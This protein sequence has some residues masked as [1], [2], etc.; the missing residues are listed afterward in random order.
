MLKSIYFYE[1]KHWLKQPS[2]Y[3]FVSIMFLFGLGAMALTADITGDYS[4]IEKGSRRF[5]NAPF[6]IASLLF[7]FN[8]FIQFIVPIFIAG[9]LYRD[10]SS[11]MFMILYSYPI[12]KRDYLFGKFLSSVSICFIIV[13][14][15]FL[16]MF[17]GSVLPW[18]NQ[19][20]ITSNSIAA[21]IRPLFLIAV[22]NIAITAMLVYAAV[23]ASRSIY[24]GFITALLV[25]LLR[26]ILVF[27]LSGPDNQTLVA[28]F[29]LFA[30]APVFMAA[31]YWTPEQMNMLN[32]PISNMIIYN[33][34]IWLGF[35]SLIFTRAYQKFAFTQ[36]ILSGN[37]F[38]KTLRRKNYQ[39]AIPKSKTQDVTDISFSFSFI[40]QVRA[41]W[42]MSVFEFRN[43]LLSRTFLALLVGSLIFMYLLLAQ[44]NP[45]YTTRI[46]PLTQVMLMVPSLFFSFIIG[47]ITFLYAGILIHKDRTTDIHQLVDVTPISNPVL[48]GSK[49]LALIK[50]QAVLLSVIMVVGVLVQSIRG[51]YHFEIDLYLF[52][53]YAVS[54]IGLVI[55]A[56]LGFF[57]QTLLPNQYVGFFLLILF[58]IG[59]GGLESIGIKPDIFKFNAAP[60][61]EYSDLNG[62]GNQ[63]RSYFAHKLYWL[64]LGGILLILTFLFWVRGFAQNFPERVV[65]ALKRSSKPVMAGSSALLLAFLSMGFMLY[66]SAYP[67]TEDISEKEL[68]AHT[69]GVIK[70][71][72]NLRNI[73]QPR[74]SGVNINM[75]IFP[76]ERNYTSNGTLVFVNK[77]EQAID[78]LIIAYPANTNS[79]YLLGVNF[80][81]LVSDSLLNLDILKLQDPLL[82]KD[83]LFLEFSTND[84]PGTFFLSNSKV[85]EN[86]T[87][88]LAELFTVGMPDNENTH[89]LPSNPK[90]SENSYVGKNVDPFDFEAVVSTS[91]DQIALA[92]GE[93]AA[94]WQENGRNYFRYKSSRKIRNGIVFNSGVF[95]VK[96]EHVNGVDLEIYHHPTHTFN[97]ERMMEAMKAT[98]AFSEKTYTPYQFKQM[99]IIEFPK[100]YGNFAQSF[101]NTIPYSEFA[102]FISKEDTFSKNRFDQVFRLVAHEMAHQWWG[103]QVVPS[104]ALGS[105]IITEGLA[106]YTSIEILGEKYGEEAKQL[107]LELISD[108]LQRSIARTPNKSTPLVF[109]RPDQD[110]LNYQKAALTYYAFQKI[111]GK[112]NFH[113]GLQ[114][115]IEK[116]RLRSSPYP[117]SLDLVNELRNVTPDSFQHIISD[118]FESDTTSVNKILVKQKKF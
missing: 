115:F 60:I 19:A 39:S 64:L 110:I 26:R 34:L 67:G 89:T 92:P 108:R 2:T 65:T 40:T 84:I 32:I 15:L 37:I 11:K 13:L 105:R 22:P 111:I 51:Y 82:P 93:L 24:A 94:Q 30:Q 41:A 53:L 77:S 117:T 62:Y 100:T 73:I 50:I 54:L 5:A 12:K 56:M 55:W 36:S 45:Q 75:N 3:L 25:L 99:R 72:G 38:R 70:K 88:M 42:R 118:F 112:D 33:R 113:H 28:L 6:S 14:F 114:N 16:G 74:L 44:A 17:L 21:Y 10:Y 58:S 106:E 95:E 8:L 69:S 4:N 96:R 104:N 23:I 79:E 20:M 18:V 1:I 109:A 80:E 71:F 47:L 35:S 83:S 7:D 68:R 91:K 27:M 31:R 49:F 43:I 86:G 66:H 59:I 90:A 76:E 87:F 103:H 46:Y 63:L 57:V 81:V 85:I 116:Y 102:G 78:T 101:A 107:Y 9:S 48:L 61:L 29:D 98:L 52:D 97:L